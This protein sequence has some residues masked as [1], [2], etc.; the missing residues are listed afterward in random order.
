MQPWLRT[1]VRGLRIRY[2]QM[3]DSI[4]ALLDE[5]ATAA[6]SAVDVAYIRQRLAWVLAGLRDQ[7]G[8]ESDLI[9]EAYYDAF[10]SDLPRDARKIK[11]T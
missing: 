9:Y 10:G 3:Q 4:A 1:R 5:L 2:A 6:R 7:Q 11:P 8:R